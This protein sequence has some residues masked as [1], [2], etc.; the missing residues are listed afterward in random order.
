MKSVIF[1]A[2]TLLSSSVLAQS[3][4]AAG[5]QGGGS[6]LPACAQ[7]CALKAIEASKCGSEDPACVCKAPGF[8]E[9]Y[10][11]CVDLSCSPREAATAIAAGIRLCQAA[12]VTIT[13]APSPTTE[14]TSP[15][16]ASVKPVVPV[17]PVVPTEHPVATPT[18]PAPIPATP[19]PTAGANSLGVG[20]ASLGLA[21]GS[22]MFLFA[23]IFVLISPFFF[24]P[25]MSFFTSS[26]SFFNL[27]R[28]VSHPCTL[29]ETMS[30]ALEATASSPRPSPAPTATMTID[31]NETPWPENFSDKDIRLIERI[32]NIT[33]Q[34]P[35]E[36][37]TGFP[38]TCNVPAIKE[39]L[40]KKTYGRQPPL[41][42]PADAS[43]ARVHFQVPKVQRKRKSTSRPST[44]P[45]DGEP[46]NDS[47][48][49][50]SDIPNTKTTRACSDASVV[51]EVGAT[52]DEEERG[53]NASSRRRRGHDKFVV[54]L[55]SKKKPD[56]MPERKADT[57]HVTISD[58]EASADGN[59]NAGGGHTQADI[60]LETPCPKPQK[61]QRSISATPANPF[62]FKRARSGSGASQPALVPLATIE[63]AN[64]DDNAQLVQ[65]SQG[66]HHALA[67]H[68]WILAKRHE[69]RVKSFQTH[70]HRLHMEL[71]F[72][73]PSLEAH[74]AAQDEFT[75]SAARVED[76]RQE[77]GRLLTGRKA[78]EDSKDMWMEL[79]PDHFEGMEQDLQA[80]LTAN[81]S[82]LQEAEIQ[83]GI[84]KVTYEEAEVAA[85]PALQLT[86]REVPKLEELRARAEKLGKTI[87]Q[88]EFLRLL[89]QKGLFAVDSI[90]KRL[91]PVGLSL[92]DLTETI[93]EDGKPA[94]ENG[95]QSDVPMD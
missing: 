27:H 55:K 5:G 60:D 38:E 67:N 62:N 45:D 64:Y 56:P 71:E 25:L 78:M 19:V 66:L 46:E 80:K 54:A 92:K 84:A 77:K 65:E 89:V 52:D 93:V 6:V 90:E 51:K 76:L 18:A 50:G 95:Q 14:S 87:E 35:W 22:I 81:N 86:N 85:G 34:K 53:S 36:W 17:P 41:L 59:M 29:F 74:R 68:V 4:P 58:G 48:G 40:Q 21:W 16:S 57:E 24:L 30:H 20:A 49:E 43:L 44:F 39:F 72:H 13:G 70:Q 32:E 9:A 83:H 7:P 73:Q 79:S 23:L 69:D 94:E 11:N 37:L 10:V 75:A 28:Y 8:A 12:G 3:T 91:E 47:A 26:P 1:F 88:T 61:R 15:E 82:A 2:T 31:S 42:R 63:G 33:G